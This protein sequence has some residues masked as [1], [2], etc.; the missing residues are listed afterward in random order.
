MKIFC[1]A[2]PL[3]ISNVQVKSLLLLCRLYSLLFC[4][5]VVLQTFSLSWF[6]CFRWRSSSMVIHPWSVLIYHSIF[7]MMNIYFL[8]QIRYS[9]SSSLT[10]GKSI[11]QGRYNRIFFQQACSISSDVFFKNKFAPNFLRTCR[12]NNL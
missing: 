9:C 12:F 2:A 6:H 1:A 7:I 5:V 10:R 11:L 3:M 4:F 8:N